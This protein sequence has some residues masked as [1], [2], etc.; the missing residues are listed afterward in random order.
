MDCGSFRTFTP[1]NI[2]VS[3]FARSARN[4]ARLT[5]TEEFPHN[6]PTSD[7]VVT[8]PKEVSILQNGIKIITATIGAPKVF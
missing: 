6:V 3:K 5:A 4:F 7:T 1:L 2:L 8:S